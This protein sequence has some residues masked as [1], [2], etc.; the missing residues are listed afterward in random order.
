[1]AFASVCPRGR[2]RPADGP[3]SRLPGGP[4]AGPVS[5]GDVDVFR[6]ICGPATP[7]PRLDGP[8]RRLSAGRDGSPQPPRARSL[9][10]PIYQ[11]IAKRLEH[12]RPLPAMAETICHGDPKFNNLV[13]SQREGVWQGVTMVDLDTVGPMSPAHEFGDAMRSWCN[14]AGEDSE[15]AAYDPM[16][17][18]KAA[19]GYFS[20]LL[21]SSDAGVSDT[22]GAP[23]FK[24]PGGAPLDKENV[25]E[26]FVLAPEWIS[27]EL[28]SR[29]A[30]DIINQKI[31]GWNPQKHASRAKA[32][33][34]RARGQ[35]SLARAME[36][37]RGNRRRVL[38]SLIP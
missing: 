9:A 15:E 5:I 4:V 25:V 16:F 10:L 20:Q 23:G 31:F 14:T 32:N 27:L 8:Y 29:F 12:L 1:M 34:V 24:A 7:S 2:V 35:M 19:E 33:W 38:R 36:A 11:D 21:A 22:V 17:F 6:S 3:R 30:R 18:Q 26:A 37:D 13:F 28:A